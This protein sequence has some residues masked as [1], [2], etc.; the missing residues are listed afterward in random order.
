MT[1]LT[2]GAEPGGLSVDVD[3]VV[4][5]VVQSP[6][7]H[8]PAAPR[9]PAPR[10]RL[11][12]RWLNNLRAWFG[13]PWERRL[14]RAALFVPAIRHW[15]AEYDRRDDKELESAGK[16]LRG[17]ARGGENLEHLLAEAFGLVC[18]AAKRFIGLR[19]FDVQLAGGAVMHFG[20]LAELATGEGKTLTAVLPTFLNA[21]AGK[22][23]HIT[24]VN[25]YLAR[26][27]AEWMGP[28]YRALGLNVGVLQMQMDEGKRREA[29][30][31]DVTYGMASEFGFDF[32]R[33]RLKVAG[34]KGQEAPF[35]SAWLH[36]GGSGGPPEVGV[37]RGHPFA[38]VDEADNIFIDEARTPL[39]IANPTRPAT[40]EESIVF[41]WA[42]TLVRQMR[43]GEHFQLDA[44]KNKL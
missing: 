38:L 41:V 15:E 21:L 26:R 29:Y 25:D 39:I 8:A 13:L 19:P 32:L 2:V 27:D 12:Q 23:T 11:G 14:A 44:K 7:G 17:R 31:C 35:W 22:G 18:V 16:R 30:K 42:D 40:P 33:D 1:A 37:Q 43:P 34:G 3:A 20:G 4:A 5:D 10:N 9:P 36:S 28:I 24:T 6:A